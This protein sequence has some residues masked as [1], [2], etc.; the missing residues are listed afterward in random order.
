MCPIRIRRAFTLIELLV[1]VS[2]LAM[3]FSLLLP[4]LRGARERAKE[5]KC[6]A[7]LRQIGNIMHMY[8]AEYEDAFPFE[9]Q[10]W[11]AGLPSWVMSAFYYGGHP[12]RPP[13]IEFRYH[14]Y[15]FREK[16]FNRYVVPASEL[17]DRVESNM[18]VGTPEFEA[19]RRPEAGWDIFWCPSDTGGFFNSEDS[20]ESRHTHPLH[21]YHGASYDINYH[22]V[23]LWAAGASLGKAVP[24][25]QRPRDA[26]YLDR[27]EN[28]LKAQRQRDP[29]RFVMLYEDPFDSS[30]YLRIPRIGWHGQWNRHSFLFLDGHAANV[31]ADP[32][33]F[34]S[35]PDWKTSGG[36]W[37]YDPQSPDYDLRSLGPN[38]V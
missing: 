26:R 28:F 21:Y 29:A 10:A 30:Q 23:W 36:A 35:G 14:R 31:Y 32:T 13:A 17:L 3:L 2:I 11:P 27:A 34:Y 1:V 7:N 12:G 33:E 16:P 38:G 6:V 15:T 9:R 4:T 5:V 8:F 25:Y 19:R 22:W 24:P 20:S 18:E 37:Y